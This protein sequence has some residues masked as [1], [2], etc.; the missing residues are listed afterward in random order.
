M[1]SQIQ[2]ILEQLW[3]TQKELAD[4]ED[5]LEEQQVEN[6]DLRQRQALYRTF[7]ER[8]PDA[9]F[10]HDLNGR[11][12]YANEVSCR[13]MG[14]TMEELLE[15]SVQDVEYGLTPEQI[16]GYWNEVMAGKMVHTQGLLKRKDGSTV[17]VDIRIGLFDT[18]ENKIIYGIARDIS[19]RLQLEERLRHVHK[20]EAVGTLAGGIAHNFNNILGIILGCAE[21]A[22]DP[23]AQ[24]HPSYGYLKEIKLAVLRAK[25]V[26]GQLLSFSRKS[27]RTKIPLR[28]EPLV[29]ESLKLMRATVSANIELHT[30]IA[31]ECYM[32]MAD[33]DQIH[34][35]V[36]NLCTNAAHATRD[37]GTIDI[38]LK[39]QCIEPDGMK[40]D[41]L[42]LRGR[43]LQLTIR[44][45]GCGMAP[46][47]LEHIFDPYFTT[48]EVGK[49]SGL[50]LAVVHGIV[51]S[52]GGD[53]KVESK[54][55]QGTT[56]DI[57]IPAIEKPVRSAVPADK[58]RAALP[59]GNERI[60]VVDDETMIVNGL[61]KRLQGLG[62]IVEAIAD[63][64]KAIEM[65]SKSPHRFDLMITD[66]AM[67]G[68]TGE[69]LTTKVKQI[70]ADFPV[71]LCTGFSER[72][73]DKTAEEIGAAKRLFKPIDREELARSV[74]DAL[75]GCKE[76]KFD[77]NA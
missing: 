63:P 49:G 30:D 66:M 12:V 47:V 65:F 59:L 64:L 68:M 41:S 31:E 33:P 71:I 11:F 74:R 18:L 8:A 50:G 19:E 15:K 9:F 76:G 38:S 2:Q 67:P 51:Q 43:Y 69:V 60:L 48:R 29:K 5:R 72:I 7:I 77:G 14:Y 53:I 1:E 62:Y 58:G 52:L 55:G 27:D 57:Y 37:G 73:D 56:F 35:M 54:P 16:Q 36:I 26:I 24:G 70:R 4:L 6:D 10:A 3:S 42:G 61:K 23:L 25:E 17:P 20:M 40:G 22:G 13:V 75:D 39:N 44:D 28:I 21:L 34:Q 45:S 32:V 46:E